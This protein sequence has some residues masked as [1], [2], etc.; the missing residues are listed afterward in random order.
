MNHTQSWC[1]FPFFFGS[2]IFNVWNQTK[3]HFFSPLSPLWPLKWGIY[4]CDLHV[5]VCVCFQNYA[6]YLRNAKPPQVDE[7][8]LFFFFV[9]NVAAAFNSREQHNTHPLPPGMS[10]MPTPTTLQHLERERERRCVVQRKA[11][12]VYFFML[13]ELYAKYFMRVWRGKVCC[14]WRPPTNVLMLHN[15]VEGGIPRVF[16]FTNTSCSIRLLFY[17]FFSVCSIARFA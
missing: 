2:S 1:I 5:C 12:F 15:R 11:L 14:V 13:N 8:I 4:F 7:A 17:V 9:C 3:P 16:V 10:G 6:Y